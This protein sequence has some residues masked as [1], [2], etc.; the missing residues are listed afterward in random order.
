MKKKVLTIIL[1]LLSCLLIPATAYAREGICG[2]EGG[3]SSGEVPGKTTYDYK[4]VTFV[5]G[6]PVVLEGTMTIK[7]SQRQD[8]TTTTYN[9]NLRNVEKDATLTRTV[10]FETISQKHENGQTTET[11]SIY[12]TPTETLRIGGETFTLL[13][14][15]GY[16]FTRS[17]LIDHHPAVDFH[18]GSLYS[19]KIYQKGPA[20]DGNTVTVECLGEYNGYDQYWGNA[21]AIMLNYSIISESNNGGIADEWGGTAEVT[22]SA[23][24]TEQLEYQKNKPNQISFEGSFLQSRMNNNILKYTAKLPEF[25]A[26]GISTDHIITYTDSLMIETFPVQKRLPTVGSANIR[27]HWSEEAIRIM[28]GLEVFKGNGAYFKPD[29]YMS[30]A[31]FATAMVKIAKEVPIDPAIPV[32][33]T[34]SSRRASSKEQ[35]ISP[36]DDVSIENASFSYIKSAYERGLLN[37]KGNNLFGPNDT[38]TKA[39]AITA[40]I[41]ALGLESLAPDPIAVTSFRDNELIPSY[42]RNAAYTAQKL[43]LLKGDSRGNMNPGKKLTKA[44][45]AEMFKNLISYLQNGIRKDYRERLVNY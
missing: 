32:R 14:T 42:A 10:V 17:N 13:R 21:E 27:G 38:I 33:A 25:D 44:E 34:A 8:K 30:R 31:E 6:E 9:Y 19:R 2:Y 16:D 5:T 37:G 23:T 26:R 39:D 4:E 11:A 7:K 18:Q 28:F 36:F 20:S 24:S 45:G 12:K 41:R 1:L 3:I 40:I 15:N 29:Q 22:I 43:G 35:V